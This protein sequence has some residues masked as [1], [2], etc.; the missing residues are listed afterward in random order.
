MDVELALLL[1]LLGRGVFGLAFVGGSEP[2]LESGS[3]LG[4][5]MGTE[6][7]GGLELGRGRALWLAIT[8][9]EGIGDQGIGIRVEGAH[10]LGLACTLE[11]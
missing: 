11:A 1:R 2:G 4:I 5:A 8:R 3:G 6:I 10:D 9:N 7:G